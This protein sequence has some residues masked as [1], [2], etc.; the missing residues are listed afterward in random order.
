MEENAV[1]VRSWKNGDLGSVNADKFVSDLVMEI[2]EKR[3]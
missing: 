2:A 1:A 3:R